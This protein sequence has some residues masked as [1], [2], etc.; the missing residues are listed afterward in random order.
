MTG[1]I[2]GCGQKPD[3]ERPTRTG[4]AADLLE[5]ESHPTACSKEDSRGRKLVSVEIS[6]SYQALADGTSKSRGRKNMIIA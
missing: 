3:K 1:E 2:E 4:A 5:T 6:N